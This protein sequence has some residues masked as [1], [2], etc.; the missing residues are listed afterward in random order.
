LVTAASLLQPSTPDGTMDILLDD[1]VALPV[2]LLVD[3]GFAVIAVR[4]R[5]NGR[6][7]GARHRNKRTPIEIQ[8]IA[9]RLGSASQEPTVRRLTAGANG[10][11]TASPSHEIWTVAARKSRS[12][13]EIRRYPSG[14]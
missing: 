2:H 3:R 6:R 14:P 5:R 12:A 13:G 11:R 7:A 1:R 9:G 10:I 4:A 8:T